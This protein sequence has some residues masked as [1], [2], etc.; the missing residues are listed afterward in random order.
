MIKI[1][2]FTYLVVAG[3]FAQTLKAGLKTSIEIAVLQ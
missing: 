2:T 3:A 1:L